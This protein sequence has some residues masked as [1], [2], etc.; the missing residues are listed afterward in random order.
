MLRFRHLMPPSLR[1][2]AMMP[3]LRYAFFAADAA[4]LFQ[5]HLLRRL[6]YAPRY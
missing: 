5:R 6:I 2:H 3:Y 1:Q 4:S